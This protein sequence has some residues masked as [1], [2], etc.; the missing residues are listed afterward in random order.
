MQLLNYA[1]VVQNQ[2][3]TN[4]ND[5]HGCVLI[6]LY[7]QDRWQAGFG[8]QAAVCQLLFCIVLVLIFL[9]HHSSCHF[10]SV[11]QKTCN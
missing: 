6:K 9:K 11:L 3:Q 10:C 5:G 7:L 2:P 4:I 8:S 1:V